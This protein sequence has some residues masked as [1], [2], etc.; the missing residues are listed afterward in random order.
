VRHPKEVKIWVSPETFNFETVFESVKYDLLGTHIVANTMM[1]AEKILTNSYIEEE[2][3]FLR[4]AAMIVSNHRISKNHLKTNLIEYRRLVGWEVNKIEVPA[5]VSYGSK[6]IKHAKSLNEAEY[7]RLILSAQ[8]ICKS[9]FDD[10][11]NRL[12]L[13]KRLDDD[14]YFSLQRM[15]LECFYCSEVTDEILIMDER[16]G[17]RKQY[18]AYRDLLDPERREWYDLANSRIDEKDLKKRQSLFKNPFAKTPL[19]WKILCTTPIFDGNK[20][21]SNVEYYSNELDEFIDVVEQY[22]GV[23]ETQFNEFKIRT[24]LR[25]KPAQQLGSFLKLVGLANKT[26]YMDVIGEN[27]VSVMVLDHD[28]LQRLQYLESLEPERDIQWDSIHERYGF[29]S[30]HTPLR[31]TN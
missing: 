3:D 11:E 28:R 26:K 30:S 15:K 5:D 10:L 12:Q 4:M 8:P 7:R 31:I 24:D 21:L 29:E 19:L 18:W 9:E 16:W 14:Q 27:K 2:N 20:F 1:E 25:S 13:K 23:I 17:L 6:L 22:K